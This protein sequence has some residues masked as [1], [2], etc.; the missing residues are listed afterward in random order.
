MHS[1]GLLRGDGDDAY[2]GRSAHKEP[3]I[4][5]R[6]SAASTGTGVRLFW[7]GEMSANPAKSLYRAM[8]RAAKLNPYDNK[9]AFAIDRIRTEFRSAR[10]LLANLRS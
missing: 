5:A 1:E 2:C 6:L 8:L 9:R 10:P 4:S 3:L 7:W